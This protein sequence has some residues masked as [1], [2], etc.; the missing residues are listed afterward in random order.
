MSAILETLMAA[1]RQAIRENRFVAFRQEFYARRQGPV[2]MD[3][4]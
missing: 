3:Q 1:A 2:T 4:E